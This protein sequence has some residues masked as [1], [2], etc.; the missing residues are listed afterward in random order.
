MSLISTR[1]TLTPQGVVALSTTE[2]SCVLMRSRSDSSSSSVIDPITVRMLVIAKL[3]I[4]SC[5]LLTS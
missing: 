5:R 3:S 1:C 2:S 4:E